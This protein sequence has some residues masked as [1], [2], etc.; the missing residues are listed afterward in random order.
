ML[1]R[2]VSFWF[3][4]SAAA[5]VQYQSFW[6]LISYSSVISQLCPGTHFLH[7][8]PF[9]PALSF[10]QALKLSRVLKLCPG[11]EAFFGRSNVSRVL[12]LFQSAEAFS[13][14]WD[15]CDVSHFRAVFLHVLQFS[16]PSTFH[17]TIDLTLC[18]YPQTMICYPQNVL[19]TRFRFVEVWRTKRVIIKRVVY[20]MRRVVRDRRDLFSAISAV[21]P[22]LQHSR[23]KCSMHAHVLFTNVPGLPVKRVRHYMNQ[24][25]VVKVHPIWDIIEPY[26][27]LLVSVRMTQHRARVLRQK[28]AEDVTWE[29]HPGLIDPRGVKLAVKIPPAK[30][31]FRTQRQ[32]VE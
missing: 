19:N 8:V 18:A 30:I 28:F 32:L 11:A 25:V 2:N 23:G 14:D 6:S 10:P 15:R 24:S 31:L 1:H 20:T 12:K 27:D 4:W 26:R 16:H 7:R 5:L 13:G 9:L 22:Q 21:F 3:K 29:H 17:S